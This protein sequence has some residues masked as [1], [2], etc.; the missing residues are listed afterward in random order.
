V[1]PNVR[2]GEVVDIA[3]GQ[4][5][6]RTEPYCDWPHVGGDNIESGG[7]RLFGLR[8]ARELNL[9]SGKYEFGPN[10]VLY[11]K[12]RPALNKVA[13]P[14]FVGICSADMYP[15]RARSNRLERRYLAYLL[16]QSDFL[17]Y[18]EKHSSRT[19]IPKI[20]RDA[21]L[22]YELHL[23][24]LAEQRR[25]A[26]ILDKADAIRRKRKAAI[27]L[28]EKLLRS[29]FL[30]MFGDPVQNPKQWPVAP[31]ASLARITTGNTPP[32]AVL[33]YFGDDIEW[34]KSDNINTPGHYLTRASEGLSAKG[35]AVGRAA[36]AG[37]TLMTCIAG[38]P[39]CIGNV[40]LADRE[41]AFNQQINALT[42]RDGVDHRYLYV[43]LL[44]GKSL[45]QSAS[46]NSMKG[47]VSKGKLEEVQVPRPEHTMQVAFGAVFEGILRLNRRQERAAID[48]DRVFES[49]RD[50][51]FRDSSAHS[52][53]SKTPQPTGQLDDS[54]A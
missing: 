38:S 12:I 48:A 43:L 3:S 19:N 7:G 32:R 11:S 23:P 8:T 47:M 46:T 30:E 14:D 42:P 20:N 28:N 22:G 35:R 53:L 4:V 17:S 5:D 24:P 31:L 13:L 15:L 37:S 45:V 36:P 50:E 34:I 21:L 26:D 33:E 54:H 2:L 44:V 49:L 51:I 52:V 18:A 27:A 1:R 16:R 39:D 10:D 29:A 40:A 6:P 41:V 9:I 25:I